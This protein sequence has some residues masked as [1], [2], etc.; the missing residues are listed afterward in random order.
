MTALREIQPE[1]IRATY[2]LTN[3]ASFVKFDMKKP[4]QPAR[5]TLQLT[6]LPGGR[7]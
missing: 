3:A 5:C 7:D 6:P 1:T 4:Y 2:I